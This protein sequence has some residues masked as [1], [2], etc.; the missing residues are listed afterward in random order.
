MRIQRAK[1]IVRLEKARVRR[2]TSDD[3]GGCG[4]DDD[5]RDDDDRDDDDDDDDRHDTDAK[6][7]RVK[8]IR[9]RRRDNPHAALQPSLEGMR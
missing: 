7:L 2:G 6:E 5:D 1:P 8:F 3:D 9:R 4:G